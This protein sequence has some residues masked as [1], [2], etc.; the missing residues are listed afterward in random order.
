[1]FY[2]TLILVFIRLGAFFALLPIFFPKGTPNIV[3]VGFS[4]LLAFILTETM[5][6]GNIKD[7]GTMTFIL[8]CMKEVITGLTLGYITNLIFFSAKLGGQLID[9]QIG[10]SMINM[11]DPTTGTNVTVI[12]N[13]LY[14]LS[15][16]LYFA[17]DGHH[18][19]IRAL[20]D[21][22]SAIPLGTYVLSEATFYLILKAFVTFFSLGLKIAIPLILIIL[23]ADIVMGLVSRTVPQLNIMI[24]GLPVKLIVG[25]T[26]LS[27]ALPILGKLIISVFNQYPDLIKGLF[28]TIPLVFIF[29][30]EDKTE[31]AT[32]KKLEEAK[33]K[34]QMPKSK[35]VNIAFTLLGITLA[36]TM[37]GGF[38][39][40]SIQAYLK[41]YLGHYLNYELTY[42]NLFSLSLNFILR[43]MIFIMPI[44][45]P[46]MIFGI[47][48]NY[49]QTGFM[50]T[51]ETLKPDLSKI[52]P[53]SGFKRMFSMRTFLNLFKDLAVVSL[54]CYEGYKYV[55]DNY[56]T[57]TS[58][59]FLPL[60]SVLKSFGGVVIS[61]FY[62]ITLILIVF[63]LIDFIYQRRQFK[64]EM[65]MTKQE[66]KE[67]MKQQEGDP[68]IK[69]KLRQKGREL[70]S[71]RMMQ[72]VPE[73]TVVITNPTHIA[74]ALKYEE[75]QKEAPIVVAKG[76][77]LVALRIKEIA[78]ENNV[79][80][81]ENKP[82]ARLI[83]KTVELDME[84]PQDMYQTVAE[85]LA[86][87][88]K[89]NKKGRRK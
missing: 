48:S 15:M 18:V 8:L 46:V 88:Y 27:L 76:A 38:L 30:S 65:R 74:I 7:I 25:L 47:L 43:A 36:L 34:G 68:L 39:N 9:T 29:A 72:K 37:F 13:L 62:K 49:V 53:I 52:N 57:I 16:M 78:K 61:I 63:A 67:E 10:F 50:F 75:G 1:M 87:M 81:V 45:I 20:I 64:K 33:K 85:I 59:G 26:A 24:L 58:M 31:D 66:I 69:S 21:S 28:K 12:E 40:S 73:A 70:A 44:A 3:K 71:R 6:L 89:I 5:K 83:Y 80:I 54:L 22:F 41:N 77:D 60:S 35:D 17:V 42:N 14:W 86:A 2:L 82:L 23:I 19:L 84:I 32:P 4:L 55:K 51:T 56:N 79:P 11:F